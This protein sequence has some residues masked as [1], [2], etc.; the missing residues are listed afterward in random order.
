MEGK[1]LEEGE[2]EE[3]TSPMK[4]R[5]TPLVQSELK[6][7]LSLEPSDELAGKGDG[8]LV[9]AKKKLDANSAMQAGDAL[10]EQV[11][12][13]NKTDG[14]GGH[15]FKSLQRSLCKETRDY[16]EKAHEK[17]R[18][19]VKMMRTWMLMAMSVP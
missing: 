15:C 5:K 8:E 16:V 19:R 1:K 13:K 18:G 3:V 10:K 14:D 9:V 11:T 12:E 7:A 2:E 4:T 6:K 17:K